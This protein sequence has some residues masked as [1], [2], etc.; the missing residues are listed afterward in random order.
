MIKYALMKVGVAKTGSARVAFFHQVKFQVGPHLYSFHEWEHGIMRGNRKAPHG[1][2]APLGKRDPRR[3]LVVSKPDGRIH[4][5]LNCGANSC[6]PIRFF[7]GDALHR[8]LRIVTMGFCED[9]A[10]VSVKDN[11]LYVSKIFMWYRADFGEGNTSVSAGDLPKV[12]CNY[13]HMGPKKQQLTKLLNSGNVKL[14]PLPYDWSANAS[15][16]KEFKPRALKAN[17]SR[18]HRS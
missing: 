6:P 3:Q 16:I 2:R 17:C 1:L 9:E 7:T 15:E 14:N 18:F 13:M 10:N 8:E 5:A 4:F 12:V 11:A